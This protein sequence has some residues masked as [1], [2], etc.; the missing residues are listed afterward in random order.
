MKILITETEN[1][2]YQN[3][4][5]KRFNILACTWVKGSRAKDFEDFDTLEEAIEHYGLTEVKYENKG[6]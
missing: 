5:G 1:G 4:K 6:L 3:K 2:K